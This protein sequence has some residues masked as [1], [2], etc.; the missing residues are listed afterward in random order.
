M[1]ESAVFVDEESRKE[2]IKNFT[3]MGANSPYTYK[4]VYVT[5]GN[6]NIETFTV[7]PPG[8]VGCQELRTYSEM[9]SLKENG[10]SQRAF[11]FFFARWCREA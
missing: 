9:L 1:N 3:D 11:N 4:S 6:R 7:I 10:I 8:V 5:T 2:L